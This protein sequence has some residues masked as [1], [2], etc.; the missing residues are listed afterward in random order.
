MHPGLVPGV[1]ALHRAIVKGGVPQTSTKTF[2]SRCREIVCG[3]KPLPDLPA[4]SPVEPAMAPLEEVAALG[5]E[6]IG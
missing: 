3:G 1:Q 5:F 4:A 6:D 2:V